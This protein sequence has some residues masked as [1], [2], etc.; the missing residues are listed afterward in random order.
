VADQ[1]P[2]FT[3]FLQ[4]FIPPLVLSIFFSL[5]PLFME[6]LSRAEMPVGKSTAQ[7]MALYVSQNSHLIRSFIHSFAHS[8]NI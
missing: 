1:N 7:T 3:N 8:G 5:I 2:A 4:G 6:L